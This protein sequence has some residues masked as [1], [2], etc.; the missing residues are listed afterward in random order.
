MPNQ[1]LAQPSLAIPP[2]GYQHQAFT[3]TGFLTR[4]AAMALHS[5]IQQQ[6]RSMQQQLAADNS[7][8]IV[9]SV[10]ASQQLSVS[11]APGYQSSPAARILPAHQ[12]S[13]PTPPLPRSRITKATCTARATKRDQTR[14]ADQRAAR[15]RSFHQRLASVNGI[16]SPSRVARGCRPWVPPPPK[17]RSSLIY[18][19]ARCAHRCSNKGNVR[20]HFP[21]CVERNGN[22]DGL[23]WD[24]AINGVVEAPL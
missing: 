10:P 12:P 9:L 14:T 20:Q 17:R 1:V 18:P 11:A 21:A 13:L 3:S 16:A 19:C 4:S 23:R 7:R 6:L 8:Y 24:D 2:M 15:Q 22:P 5:G